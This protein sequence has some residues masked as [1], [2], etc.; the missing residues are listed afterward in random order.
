MSP[1]GGMDA[2]RTLGVNQ[3]F[4][5]RSSAGD[6]S[7]PDRRDVAFLERIDWWKK[8]EGGRRL[9]GNPR[10]AAA[11]GEEERKRKGK[12]KQIGRAHV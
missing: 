1:R 10:P 11:E 7:N 4:R 9:I 6:W 5:N 12:R 3:G 8:E 2:A